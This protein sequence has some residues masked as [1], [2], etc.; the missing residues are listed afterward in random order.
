VEIKT[1][2]NPALVDFPSSANFPNVHN[3][4]LS[5]AY[6]CC[7]FIPSTYETFIPEY[8]DDYDGTLQ[9]EIWLPGTVCKFFKKKFFEKL[10]KCLKFFFP[11]FP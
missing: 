8:G 7:Q 1:H 6:H 2:N 5:Y 11:F 3:L 9:Q 4:V 10:R